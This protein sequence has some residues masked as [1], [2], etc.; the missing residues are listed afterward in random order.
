VTD[1]AEEIVQEVFLHIWE[2][3]ETW[4]VRTSVKSYFFTAFRNA[5][6]SYYSSRSN[7]A[8]FRHD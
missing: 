1:L 3:G 8:F 6:M 5:A 7:K 4:D 2:R